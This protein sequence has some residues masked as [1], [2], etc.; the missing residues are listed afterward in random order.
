MTAGN[1]Y[2]YLWSNPG[3]KPVRVSAPQYIDNVLSFVET[4]ISNEDLFPTLPNKP[5]GSN[6]RTEVKT[7]FKR[8]FRVF[9]HIY[10]HHFENVKELGAEAHLNTCFKYFT[11]FAMEFNMIEKKELAPLE[12]LINVLLP[13][14]NN[15]SSPNVI[16]STGT[17]SAVTSTPSTTSSSSSSVPSVNSVLPIGGTGGTIATLPP[18]AMGNILPTVSSSSLPTS[19]NQPP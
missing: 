7:A 6:F 5:F 14:S 8:L 12:E 16:P 10:Y 19:S 11:L 18:S 2:E 13:D 17:V 1:K 3:K 15:S 9:A 4:L